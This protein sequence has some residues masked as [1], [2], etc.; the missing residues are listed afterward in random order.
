MLAEFRACGGRISTDHLCDK[1]VK[2]AEV[3]SFKRSLQNT[4]ERSTEVHTTNQQKLGNEV[5]VGSSNGSQV[6]QADCL[7]PANHQKISVLF[8][9]FVNDA[10][11]SLS[12]P[13]AGYCVDPW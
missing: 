13:S 10:D 8:S 2:Q 4:F 6:G 5:D 12:G 11:G 9:S 1:K 3:L 7:E